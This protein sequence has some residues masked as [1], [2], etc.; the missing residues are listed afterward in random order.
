MLPPAD[1][2]ARYLSTPPALPIYPANI[3]VK[4]S[5]TVTP[6]VVNTMED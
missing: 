2:P 3:L 1:G 4:L 5:G 6:A